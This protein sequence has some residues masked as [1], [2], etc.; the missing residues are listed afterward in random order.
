MFTS[1]KKA[2]FNVVMVASTLGDE[3][4]ASAAMIPNCRGTAKP[5][6]RN[7]ASLQSQA[8]DLSFQP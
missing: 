6:T 3:H 8:I 1:A 4:I 7:N 5:A 2:T